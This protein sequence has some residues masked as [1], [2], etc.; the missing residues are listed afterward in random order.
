[1]KNKSKINEVIYIIN[2]KQVQKI[3]NIIRCNH[4]TN[5]ILDEDFEKYTKYSITLQVDCD[6]LTN[7]KAE[8]CDN[9][10]VVYNPNVKIEDLLRL[11]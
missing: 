3:N 5:S 6:N 9:N 2:D 7:I 4:Q 1:M 10:D 11:S 8:P